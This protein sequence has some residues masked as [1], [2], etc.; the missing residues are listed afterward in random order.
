MKV[1]W[2]PQAE[3]ERNAAIDYIAEDNLVAALD[4]DVRIDALVDRLTEFPRMG[5]PGRVEGT[6]E[7]V[8]HEHYALVYELFEEEIHI[9]SFL[10]SSRQYPP[11]S[12]D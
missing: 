1:L 2:S 7:L 11:L 10:H 8:V 12:V 6:R 3:S 9:L 4:L 5:K